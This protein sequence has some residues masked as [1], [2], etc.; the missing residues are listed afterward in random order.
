[1]YNIPT[2][3]PRDLLGNTAY[4]ADLPRMEPFFDELVP[5]F[6]REKTAEYHRFVEEKLKSDLSSATD[7]MKTLANDQLNVAVMVEC[8][9]YTRWTRY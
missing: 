4:K 3:P 1:M 7:F 6:C 2:I 5:A 8:G 9:V